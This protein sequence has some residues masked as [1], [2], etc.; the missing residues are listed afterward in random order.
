MHSEVPEYYY[1]R[2]NFEKAVE[3]KL[4]LPPDKVVEALVTL[5]DAVQRDAY[6]RGRREVQQGL[7]K[8]LDLRFLLGR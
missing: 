4:K 7:I 1:P 5:L 3:L 6:G 2:V 8:V